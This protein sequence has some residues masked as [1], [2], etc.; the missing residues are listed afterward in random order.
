ML[1]LLRP[2]CL[3]TALLLATL[4]LQ[5]T[6]QALKCFQGQT[7]SSALPELDTLNDCP[8]AW[9]QACVYMNDPVGRVASRFCQSQ[10]CS[11]H[12]SP[13]PVPQTSLEFSS[14]VINRRFEDGSIPSAS[15]FC[16]SIPVSSAY[17]TSGMTSSPGGVYKV[18]CCCMAAGCNLGFPA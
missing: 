1:L 5:D 9:D 6:V 2:E 15:T 8:S 16:S 10:M 14:L 3:V 4:L 12:V 17:G 18:Y 13:V 11:N 7:S